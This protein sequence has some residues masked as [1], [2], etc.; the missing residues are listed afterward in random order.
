MKTLLLLRHAKSSWKNM[1]LADHDRPLS[2]RGKRDAPRMARFLRERDLVPDLIV[3]STAKRAL[4]T[5]EAIAQFSGYEE[6]LLVTRRLYHAWTETYIEVIR[7]LPDH[8]QRIMLVGHNPGMEELV[9][10]LTGLQERMPT[11]AL[12]QIE[13]PV[14]QWSEVNEES[15]GQLIDVWRPKEIQ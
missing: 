4:T 11:A 9:E 5:A 13:L 15:I 12:A 7:E 8:H 1:Y 6:E 2:K 3:T 10:V 14:N